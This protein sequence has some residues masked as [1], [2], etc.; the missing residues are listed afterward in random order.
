LS[1]LF[2]RKKKLIDAIHQTMVTRLS[3][4]YFNDQAATIF[5]AHNETFAHW[6]HMAESDDPDDLAG[7]RSASFSSS[8]LNIAIA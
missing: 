8:S 2:F 1:F 5:T 7:A 6:L 3:C 4:T